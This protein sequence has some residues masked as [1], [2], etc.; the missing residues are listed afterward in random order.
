MRCEIDGPRAIP[1][2]FSVSSRGLFWLALEVRPNGCVVR[3]KPKAS[4]RRH[5]QP[6]VATAEHKF[7][8]GSYVILV[9]KPDETFLK[10]KGLL[11]DGGAGLQYRIKNERGGYE[12]VA[13]ERLLTAVCR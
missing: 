11:P 2:A 8:A 5:A 3:D 7:A 13:V 9:G 6:I 10:I 1:E 4:R 12:R